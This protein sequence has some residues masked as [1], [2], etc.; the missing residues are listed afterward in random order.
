MSGRLASD[1]SRVWHGAEDDTV[2]C[3]VCHSAEGGGHRA[4]VFFA[5]YFFT[6]RIAI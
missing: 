6:V 5:A 1:M 4:G 2:L 3:V